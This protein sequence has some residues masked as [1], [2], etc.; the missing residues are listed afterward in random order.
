M[1]LGAITAAHEAE[2]TGEAV[3]A[4]FKGLVQSWNASNGELLRSTAAGLAPAQQEKLLVD[5]PVKKALPWV[6]A[7]LKM[8][9]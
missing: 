8:T 3:S 6:L 9:F 7:L 4:R 1:V 5:F 2:S